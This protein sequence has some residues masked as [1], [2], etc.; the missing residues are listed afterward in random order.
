MRLKFVEENPLGMPKVRV[1]N[2]RGEELG[3]IF[4][5]EAWKCYVWAQHENIL[6]SRDCLAQ[7]EEKQK[8]LDKG[9]N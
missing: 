5:Y 3:C 1:L 6:M 8:E 2:K 9:V 4:Y 7:V